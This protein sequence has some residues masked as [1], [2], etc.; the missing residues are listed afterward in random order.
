MNYNKMTDSDEIESS[1]G[2]LLSRTIIECYRLLSYTMITE[3]DLKL[4]QETGP[5]DFPLQFRGCPFSTAKHVS[6]PSCA[7]SANEFAGLKLHNMYLKFRLRES[8]PF[9]ASKQVVE[10]LTRSK[11]SLPIYSGVSE[12]VEMN[13]KCI[14]LQYAAPTWLSWERE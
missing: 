10:T 6:S 4:I 5:P 12:Q 3:K 2:S 8:F 14:D 9:C 7:R 1:S 11:S 13:H